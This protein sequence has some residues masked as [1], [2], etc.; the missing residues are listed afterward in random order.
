VSGADSRL[1]WR[2]RRGL[3][4]LDLLLERFAR[5]RWA[6]ASPGLRGGFERLLD[7]PDPV[8]VELLLGAADS[9]PPFPEDPELE[10]IAALV[11]DR[12]RS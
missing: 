2:C 8:L 4:E 6:G 9:V 12:G 5:E 3:K 7:L 1:L 10:Q 11:A